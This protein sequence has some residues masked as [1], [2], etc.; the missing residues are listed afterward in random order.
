MT[1]CQLNVLMQTEDQRALVR[2]YNRPLLL[3]FCRKC[4][5]S[6]INCC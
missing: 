6:F 5:V 3:K 2:D 4:K 1:F